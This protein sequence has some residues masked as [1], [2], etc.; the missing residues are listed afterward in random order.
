MCVWQISFIC[1]PERLCSMLGGIRYSSFCEG[2]FLADFWRRV[3]RN[4][5]WG[6]KY[7]PP[8]LGL[9][10]SFLHSR[11]LI[12]SVITYK[13]LGSNF[14]FKIEK[15]I[16]RCQ[17]EGFCETSN[18]AMTHVQRH[19]HFQTIIKYVYNKIEKIHEGH[20]INHGMIK[21][22]S[23]DALLTFSD[24]LVILPSK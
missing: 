17:L 13:N 4:Q 8:P 23:P 1:H 10:F 21:M 11:Y 2:Y 14:K 20:N 3:S 24:T 5:N 22:H 6:A 9:K 19:P 7:S 16:F 15:F 12:K 18:Y